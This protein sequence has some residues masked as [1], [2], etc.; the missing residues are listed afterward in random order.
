MCFDCGVEQG[1]QAI[2]LSEQLFELI[3]GGKTSRWFF[4]LKA[5]LA[6]KL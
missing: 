5:E 1:V 3:L 6:E 2:L 4:T